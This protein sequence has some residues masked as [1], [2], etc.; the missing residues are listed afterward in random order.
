AAGVH[1]LDHRFNLVWLVY[2]VLYYPF[3]L[4]EPPHRNSL[5]AKIKRQ[6]SPTPNDLPHPG[7]DELCAATAFKNSFFLHFAGSLSDI[8]LIHES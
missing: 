2:K 6:L 8:G 4:G 7:L 3:L 1:W 5:L